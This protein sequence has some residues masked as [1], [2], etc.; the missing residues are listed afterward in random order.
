MYCLWIT[1]EDA[2]VRSEVLTREQMRQLYAQADVF[3]L[4]TRGE[5][6]CLPVA[7]AMAMM[8][9]VIVTN[10]SGMTA[11]AT[12]NNAYLIPVD[13]T[14]HNPFGY[15]EPDGNALVSLLHRAYRNATER[16]FKGEAGRVTMAGISP[17]YVANI[18]VARVRMLVG[19]RG[20]F[21]Y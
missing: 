2:P 14:T 16:R 5:G 4:P 12:D 10:H 6:Y 3:V 15:V 13:N 1:V 21:D 7:E 20:W 8:L 18:M 9:P 17:S 11:Y 19:R